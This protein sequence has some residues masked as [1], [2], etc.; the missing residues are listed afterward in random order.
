[1][2]FAADLKEQQNHA[3]AVLEKVIKEMDMKNLQVDSKL[4]KVDGLNEKVE[5]ISQA[6]ISLQD[7]LTKTIGDMTVLIK[8]ERNK[9]DEDML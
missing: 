8:Q 6:Q 5:S 2:K 9:T 3:N 4:I 1:M 7:H